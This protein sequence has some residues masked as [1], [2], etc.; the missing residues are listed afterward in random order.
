MVEVMGTVVRVAAM[1]VKLGLVLLGEVMGLEVMGLEVTGTMVTVAAMEVKLG[2]VLMKEVIQCPWVAG[3][4]AALTSSLS[5]QITCLPY[6]SPQKSA[7]CVPWC[8]PQCV[9]A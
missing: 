7:P 8:G 5:D 4:C 6:S 2:L 3:M 1:E 9:C